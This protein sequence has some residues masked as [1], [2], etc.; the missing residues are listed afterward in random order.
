ML[1]VLTVDITDQLDSLL[2]IWNW[3]WENAPG[4]PVNFYPMPPHGT[5][6]LTKNIANWCQWLQ[7]CAN[8]I[9]T[10]RQN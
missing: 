8:K 5:I 4:V 3:S 2:M 9:N 6:L 7:C 10:P 1:C